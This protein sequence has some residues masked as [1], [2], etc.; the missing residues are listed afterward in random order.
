MFDLK[1]HLKK[2]NKYYSLVAIVGLFGLTVS[3]GGG[4]GGSEGVIEPQ[5][6][7]ADQFVQESGI[8]IDS[9]AQISLQEIVEKPTL[10][11]L[12][13]G[14]YITVSS[15]YDLSKLN[16]GGRQQAKS[17]VVKYY[18]ENEEVASGANGEE[19]QIETDG[20]A[21]GANK[22]TSKLFVNQVEKA[23]KKVGTVKIKPYAAVA[24]SGLIIKKSTS[25]PKIIRPTIKN[26]LK[27]KFEVERSKL[28]V[29]NKFLYVVESFEIIKDPANKKVKIIKK[30]IKVKVKKNGNPMV[31]SK[32]VW[33]GKK[34]GV[35]V[36]PGKYRYQ[37]YGKLIQKNK[38]TGKKKILAKSVK[39][40]G[41]ITSAELHG[42]DFDNDGLDDGWE[43]ENFEKFSENATGDFDGDSVTNLIEYRTGRNPTKGEIVDTNN[44]N[45]LQVFK[46]QN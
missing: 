38:T 35:Y 8:P 12:K 31:N 41:T 28:V 34:K 29:D 10:G 44:E 13:E 2:I 25:K 30:V 40:T 32:L 17:V 19:V 22:V 3:C 23:S 14:D 7:P 37:H 21:E 42:F 1:S 26:T 39:V 27:T 15:T 18:L 20:A 45:N 9:L 33:D 16:S 46:T 5:S 24:Q 36:L 6:T 11:E 43:F 4:G